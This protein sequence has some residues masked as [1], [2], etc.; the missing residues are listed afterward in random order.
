MEIQFTED[1]LIFTKLDSILE[2]SN[3]ETGGNL[4]AGNFIK[5]E[6]RDD[7]IYVILE[8]TMFTEHGEI[9]VTERVTQLIKLECAKDLVENVWDMTNE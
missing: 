2:M 8:E 4:D 3:E 1:M 7:K 6:N 9:D 5:I